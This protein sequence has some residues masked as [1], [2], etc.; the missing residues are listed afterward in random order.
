MP[1]VSVDNVT[2]KIF[3]SWYDSR[4]DVAGNLLTRLYGTTSTDGGQTFTANGSISD[5][6]FNPNSMAVGQPGG[7]NY[8][9]D[10]IGVSAI[11]NTGY[12]VW[13]DGRTNNLGSFVAYYPDFALTVNPASRNIVNGDS[14]TFSAV[15]PSIKGPF[16]ERVKFSVTVDTLPQSG[17]L[18]ITF[19]NGKDA[20]S[21]FPDSV[22]V[23]VK[24][25]GNVTPR[26]YKLN[27]KG[28]GSLTGM[29]VH[30]RTVNLLVNASQL[31]I[32]TN[33]NAICDFKVNGVQYNTTQT[34]VFSNASVITVQAISPKTIGFNRYVYVNWSDN[35]DTTHNI[36]LNTNT[37]LT[38]NYKIQYRLN[39]I[40]SV[41]HVFGDNYYDSASSV[42]FVTSRNII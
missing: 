6:S 1:T 15:A 21:T 9:G 28:R 25:V 10:Y 38:A 32:G 12:S 16:S 19:A 11:R 17:S 14:T 4:V 20:V 27:I 40:S 34:L 26:L 8:I 37:T 5:V 18:Q 30:I 24:A 29:P 33:R 22:T 2:G 23:K 39:V 7:E 42:Q 36:T 31:T 3:I 41:G 35:G 13:M